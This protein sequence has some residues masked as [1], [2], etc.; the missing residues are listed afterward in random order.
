MKDFLKFVLATVVGIIAFMIVAGV[1][2][3]MSIMGMV[4]A[5][6]AATTVEDNSVLVLDI[7]GSVSEQAQDVTINK[8]TGYANTT[9]IGLNDILSAIGK[10]KAEDK[11]KGIFLDAGGINASYATIQE[12]R[13][14]LDDF[15]KSGKWIIAYSDSYSQ[16]AYYLATVANK[17][18]INPQGMLDWHGIASQPMYYKD[19]AAKFGVRYQVV[20]VG[21]YKSATE[22]FTEDHMTDANRI[23]TQAFINGLWH[24]VCAAVSKSRG[25]S[26]DSLNRY[27]DQ[28]TAF[29]TTDMLKKR[30]MIDGTCYADEIKGIVKDQ[31]ELT[32]DDDINKLSLSDMANVKESKHDG[33]AIAVY[34]AYGD[35]VQ[36]AS[37]SPL[38]GGS[39]CIAADKVC[40]DLADLASDDDIKAVVIRVNSGGGDAYA[41]EQIW[42]Q[43]SML[44]KKKPVVVSMGDYAASGAYYMSAPASWIVAQPNTLTGSIGIFAVFPDWSGLITQKLGVKFDEVKTNRNSSFGNTLARPFNAEETAFLQQYVNRGYQLFRKRVADGRK[45]PILEVEKIAQGRV[46]VGNDAIGIK[47]VDQL[48]GLDDAVR[49]AAQLA[50]LKDFYTTEYPA[51]TSWL[52]ELLADGDGGTDLLDSHL[53]MALGDLYQPL[54]LLRNLDKREALQARMPFVP[55]IH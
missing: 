54:S 16:G 29:Q 7:N 48:G 23:Q 2:G 35:I 17:I 55:N 33:E 24:N 9:S 40:K 14:K 1:F 51:P 30:K 19:L 5:S 25:I 15:K 53:R 31:L 34:Y 45:L 18:Y 50:K 6:S 11:I 42:H 52:D 8:F 41:S 3:M 13:S 28:L 32:P 22:V 47:L 46:W 27:A 26:T 36:A 10:A 44:K 20:K 49:K 37:P 21:A 12:I 4:A 43:V 38:S 39:Q